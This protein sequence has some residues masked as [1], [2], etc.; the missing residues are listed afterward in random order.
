MSSPLSA[1]QRSTHA[2]LVV[3][4]VIEGGAET[5]I[6]DGETI[7]VNRHAALIAT[8]MGLRVGMRI[9]IHVY[10]TDKR[11]TARVVHIDPENRLHCGIELEEPRNIWG[12]ALP[13]DGL[14]GRSVSE[15]LETK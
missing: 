3:A 5:Q 11:A 7:I 6:C 15:P 10:V 13:P 4:I 14:A 8:S 1:F 2:P 12:V 9:S